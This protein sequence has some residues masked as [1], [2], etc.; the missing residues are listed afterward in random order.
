ML[1]ERTC[2]LAAGLA[3]AVCASAPLVTGVAWLWAA[4][5]VAVPAALAWA[6]SVD[7]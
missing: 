5:L 4:A 6:V 7:R 1:R 2:A 3:V